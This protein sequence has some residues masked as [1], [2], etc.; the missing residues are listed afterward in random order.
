MLVIAVESPRR[1]QRTS[2]QLELSWPLRFAMPSNYSFKMQ[3]VGGLKMLIY[4]LFDMPVPAG[5]ARR[6][7]DTGGRSRLLYSGAAD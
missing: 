3:E 6:A 1:R 7:G 5:R 2:L 4:I